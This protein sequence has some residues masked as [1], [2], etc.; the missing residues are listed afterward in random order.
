MKREGITLATIRG[1]AVEE[2]FQVVLDEV[3][4]NIEDPNTDAKTVREISIKILIKP[5]ETRMMGAVAIKVG[6]KVAGIR[7]LGT[8]FFFG[9]ADGAP[10]AMENNPEQSGF[11][12]E[13]GVATLR[14]VP[15]TEG[16]S[17]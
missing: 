5:D 7:S 16:G 12:D 15:G 8:A 4:R 6:S 9:R 3:L 10:V 11:F 1:G 14:A 13:P 17:E 2:R